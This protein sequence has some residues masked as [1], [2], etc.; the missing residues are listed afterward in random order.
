MKIRPKIRYS[1]STD[2]AIYRYRRNLGIPQQEH[3]HSGKERVVEN[4]GKRMNL[5]EVATYN[6]SDP[7]SIELI[8]ESA[9]QLKKEIC[10]TRI[11]LFAPYMSAANVQHCTC[12]FSVQRKMLRKTLS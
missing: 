3:S 10:G 7:G 4:V 12:Q 8:K 5:E 6:A 11:V 9:R 1:R 2:A